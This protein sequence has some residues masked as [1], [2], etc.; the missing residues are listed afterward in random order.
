MK[1]QNTILRKFAYNEA[2]LVFGGAN[3][4]GYKPVNYSNDFVLE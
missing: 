3:P 4:G 1:D 2:R